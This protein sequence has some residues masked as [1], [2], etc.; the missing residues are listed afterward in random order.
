MGLQAD[1]NMHGQDY[2]LTSTVLW[3]GIIA[4]EFPANRIVQRFPTAR[5]LGIAIILWGLL[6]IG[7]AFLKQAPPFL[8]FRFL[9]G[10][11]ESCVG[12]A[13]FVIMVMW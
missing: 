4:G 2:A 11:F 1:T 5:V 8:A 3:I 9:L 13:I 7:P 10:L 12:P 6:L